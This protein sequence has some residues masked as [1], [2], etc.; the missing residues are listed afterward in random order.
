MKKTFALHLAGK[1]DQR[2]LEAVKNDIRK[3][4]K[5][6]RRKAL[7][8]GVDFWDFDCKVGDLKTEPAVTHLAE[9]TDAIAAIAA[10]GGVEAYVEILAKPGRRMPKPAEP[11]VAD[12]GTMAD[13]SGTSDSEQ[14]TQERAGL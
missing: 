13:A 9:V 1:D 6:E 5:R 11:A 14:S 3:Y 7:P 8:E 10:Q 4:V 2:V 12:T